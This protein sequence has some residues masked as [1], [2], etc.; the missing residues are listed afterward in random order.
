MHRLGLFIF[1]MLAVLVLEAQVPQPLK[2]Y[3]IEEAQELCKTQPKKILIDMYTDWCGWCKKMDAETFNNPMIA[4]YVSSFYYPVKFNAETMDTI[5]FKGKK[6]TN[7]QTGKRPTHDLAIEL[8]NG[9][10]SYPTIVYLDETFNNL[11]PVA[12]FMTP[13]DIEPVLMFFGRNIYKTTSYEEFRTHFSHA[14][15]DT[16]YKPAPVKWMDFNEALKDNVKNPRDYVVLLTSDWCGECKIM[17]K[18][19]FADSTIASYIEKN[20]HMVRFNATSK[21]SI[22]FNNYNYIN[23][24]KEHPFHQLAVTM[25]N[26]KMDFP[27]IVFIS[28]ENQMITVVPGYFSPV[29]LEPLLRFFSEGTYKT[30]KWEDYVK[31]FKSSFKK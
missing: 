4:Q 21:D 31:T 6:Y 9:K 26:G 18:T 24:G 14:F 2:W 11:S 10:M 29:N 20:L 5:M 25:L 15:A 16:L 23:E 22:F 1:S 12:G 8:L 7:N 30:T 27:A 28:K 19:S 17:E 13:R 3:T